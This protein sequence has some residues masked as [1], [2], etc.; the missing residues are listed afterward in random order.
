MASSRYRI[1]LTMSLDA[2]CCCDDTIVERM[3]C[4]DRFCANTLRCT[5]NDYDLSR[6][7]HGKPRILITARLPTG[8]A[9]PIGAKSRPIDAPSKHPPWTNSCARAEQI[10]SWLDD[11]RASTDRARSR[12]HL[13]SPPLRS[14]GVILYA[15]MPP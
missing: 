10:E 9:A 5:S 7:V 6:R 12:F 13:F 8:S 2:A 14:L 11:S 3:E 15:R 4:F 1:A